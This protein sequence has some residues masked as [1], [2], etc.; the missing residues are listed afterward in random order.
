MNVL[1]FFE[2]DVVWLVCVCFK[3][4]F[5]IN[6]ETYAKRTTDTMRKQCPCFES[7]VLQDKESLKTKRN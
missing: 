3:Y 5:G 4:I 7:P 1:V 6:D 2:R